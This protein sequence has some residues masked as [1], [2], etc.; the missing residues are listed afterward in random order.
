MKNLARTHPGPEPIPTSV[1]TGLAPNAIVCQ[2]SRRL[3]G[4]VENTARP[5]DQRRW[6][7]GYASDKV[8][9]SFNPQVQG[10]SPWRPTRSVLVEHRF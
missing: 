10:S 1:G 2:V 3:R 9:A 8:E 4:G 5:Y 7:A 6:I